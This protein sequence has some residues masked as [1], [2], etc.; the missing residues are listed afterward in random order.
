MPVEFSSNIF[1]FIL[2]LT[3]TRALLHPTLFFSMFSLF[4]VFFC[5][6]CCGC[7]LYTCGF[8]LKLK[9]CFIFLYYIF[10]IKYLFLFLLF[11]VLIKY[12]TQLEKNISFFLTH[13]LSLVEI[14]GYM[15]VKIYFIKKNICISRTAVILLRIGNCI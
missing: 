8:C 1:Y 13:K 4:Q 15:L 6:I 14:I 9:I 3:D 7:K 2:K 11:F 10:W 12:F 5:I